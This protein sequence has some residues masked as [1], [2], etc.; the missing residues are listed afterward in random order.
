LNV[1]IKVS[2]AGRRPAVK[3]SDNLGKNTGD[4]AT[5]IEVKKRLGYV[6]HDWE[7]GDETRRWGKRGD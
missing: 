2:T 1:V 3:L 7:N 6:E 4:R 5:V